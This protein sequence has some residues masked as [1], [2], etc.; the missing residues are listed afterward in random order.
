MK[1]T[2]KILNLGTE[3]AFEVLAK[4][5]A[6]EAQGKDIIHLEIG[7]PD[8]DTPSHIVEAG[9]KALRDG[10]THYGP[11]AGLM[12]MREAI[13]RNSREVRGIDTVPAQV[14]VTPGAK[15]V[16]FYAILALAEPGVEVIY[17]NPGFPIYESLIRF[18]GATP[19]PMRLLEEKSYHPDL[20]DLASLITDRTRLIIINSPEN[21]CGSIL[22]LPELET[23][24]DLVRQHDDL[25][26]LT[27]E[28]YKDI[29]YTGEHHSIAA[30][31]GMAERTIIL[32]GFS[33]SY[34]MTGWRLGY[35]I[36]PEEIVPNVTRLAVNN[37]SCPATFTQIAGI[38]ALDG[39]QDAVQ[40]MA[41]EFAGRRR[42][43]TDGLRSIPGIRCPEPEGAFYA[44]PNISETGLTSRQ[45]EDR[46]MQEAGVAL[47]SGSGFGEFGEGYVRISYANSRENIQKAL[48]R[49]DTFVRGLV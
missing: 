3:A 30:L 7:E 2:S 37:I 24:A 10:Y 32:D 19:V 13:A 36:M 21:P 43:I 17:P 18:A 31:P 1:L 27:D 8:F 33:K 29:L 34:A 46:V 20:D 12:E 45:F 5:R 25:Y 23:I 28:V 44:F 41:A 42:L 48:D 22:T 49:L 40:A 15:P 16:M 38:A 39:P 6:L 4:A 35:G 11:T 14:V 47:L 9:V 26:I